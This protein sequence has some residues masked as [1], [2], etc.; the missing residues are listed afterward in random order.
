V[1]RADEGDWEDDRP[2][3]P[4]SADEVAAM[5]SDKVA[6]QLRSWMKES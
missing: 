2:T 3:L 1:H 6:Q 5:D 4:S